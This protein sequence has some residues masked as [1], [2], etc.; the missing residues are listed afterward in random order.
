M[1]A[2]C[3]R[4]ALYGFRF[5]AGA[6]VCLAAPGDG[7]R[8]IPVAGGLA[9][10]EDVADQ[11][12]NSCSLCTAS[13]G[14]AGF[15]SRGLSVTTVSARTPKRCGERECARGSRVEGGCRIVRLRHDR[16]EMTDQQHPD[17][18]EAVRTWPLWAFAVAGLVLA[19]FVPCFYAWNIGG[20]IS[21]DQQDWNN[22]GTFVGGA[23]SPVL[24]VL[25][26]F[27]LLYTV[28]VQERQLV[29]ARTAAA[30]SKAALQVQIERAR[31]DSIRT[32]FFE[33]LKLHHEIVAGVR[34]T[35]DD[36]SE[37]EGREALNF[38]YEVQF[39]S[40]YEDEDT[41][42]ERQIDVDRRAF[43][44][45]YREY[46][47]QLGHYFRNLYRIYKFLDRAEVSDK[48]NLFGI[49]RAQLG[50]S[51]MGLLFYNGL[52]MHGKRF[53]PLMQ[54]HRALNNLPVRVLMSRFSLAEYEKNVYGKR[55][56]QF[57]SKPGFEPESVGSVPVM[58]ADT[59]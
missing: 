23:L 12:A 50:E 4:G 51:E 39:R 21:S 31:E 9:T 7:T 18:R 58:P 48:R 53:K 41:T 57:P 6:V 24:S 44:S 5:A 47:H 10:P 20:G 28:F 45:F 2:Q 32:T 11:S 42:E 52:S 35:G 29:I 37:Y 34:A 36:G 1:A 38:L 22:F 8:C 26:F 46:G 3:M 56:I 55:A 30:D 13:A 27:A 49:T 16:S 15:A 40:V 59:E 54:K 17:R 19:V 25:A 14:H 43:H 33:M